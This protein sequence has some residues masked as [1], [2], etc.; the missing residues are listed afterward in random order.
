MKGGEIRLAGCS[1]LTRQSNS[2]AHRLRGRGPT[3]LL[4]RWPALLLVDRSERNS[5]RRS[6]LYDRSAKTIVDF[7]DIMK[8]RD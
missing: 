7:D 1:R 8:A 2:L 5:S 3:A 4:P 6:S